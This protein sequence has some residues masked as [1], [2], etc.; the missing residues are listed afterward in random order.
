[1]IICE[2]FQLKN[3][4][5]DWIVLWILN[6][7]NV[8]GMIEKHIITYIWDTSHGLLKKMKQNKNININIRS[9]SYMKYTNFQIGSSIKSLQFYYHNIYIWKKICLDRHV[10]LQ[11]K[12]NLCLNIPKNQMLKFLVPLNNL[13]LWNLYDLW[14]GRMINYKN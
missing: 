10:D 13:R 6:I 9:L 12:F 1:M 5:H 7:Q 3:K 11:I 8:I 14:F 4:L 2:V